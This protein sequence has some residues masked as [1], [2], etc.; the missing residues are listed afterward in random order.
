MEHV[1]Q[2]KI[3]T[4]ELPPSAYFVLNAGSLEALRRPGVVTVLWTNVPGTELRVA[5]LVAPS[6]L[7]WGLQFR[8]R[9]DLHELVEEKLGDDGMAQSVQQAFGQIGIGL[10]CVPATLIGSPV[11]GL[12]HQLEVGKDIADLPHA[13]FRTALMPDR[14]E[15]FQTF[16]ARL[17]EHIEQLGRFFLCAVPAGVQIEQWAEDEDERLSELFD[18]PLRGRLKGERMDAH[19]EAIRMAVQSLESAEAEQWLTPRFLEWDQFRPSYPLP[20]TPNN[21]KRVFAFFEMLNLRPMGELLDQ[22]HERSLLQLTLMKKWHW[23]L[24]LRKLNEAK[25]SK[26]LRKTMLG[27]AAPW[28]PAEVLV[29]EILEDAKLRYPVLLS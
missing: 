1:V 17:N 14:E 20:A 7:A 8:H 16:I 13:T 4:K 26:V 28:E 23:P 25:N 27:N 2:I 22:K 5:L 11:F 15:E 29:S 18:R 10:D 9:H 19:L 21:S 24:G 3:E 6:D 12:G